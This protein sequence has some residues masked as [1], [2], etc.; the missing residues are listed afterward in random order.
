LSLTHPIKSKAVAQTWLFGF[1]TWTRHPIG[2]PSRTLTLQKD[3]AAQVIHCAAAQ[4]GSVSRP[5]A[6]TVAIA[7][8]NGLPRNAN[9]DT[10]A[11]IGHV[12]KS[13]DGN[14]KGALR[15]LALN[16]PSPSY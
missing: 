1:G 7:R 4:V 8:E 12:T 14:F 13:Q 11:S 6:E 5:P 15:T 3:L 10:N 2:R 16:A 9:G